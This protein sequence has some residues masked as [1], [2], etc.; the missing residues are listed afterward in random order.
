LKAQFNLSLAAHCEV[1]ATWSTTSA[2]LSMG[3]SRSTTNLFRSSNAARRTKHAARRTTTA[4]GEQR[5]W[6]AADDD[7]TTIDQRNGCSCHI[8]FI[9]RRRVPNRASIFTRPDIPSHGKQRFENDINA[10]RPF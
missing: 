5:I 9:T 3:L 4:D 7:A 6:S 10:S 1:H 8:A 2:R